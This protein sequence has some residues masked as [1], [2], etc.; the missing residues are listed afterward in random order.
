MILTKLDVI[1]FIIKG[2]IYSQNT[3]DISLKNDNKNFIFKYN[4]KKKEILNELKNSISKQINIFINEIYNN[5]INNCVKE[6]MN[7]I[8]DE[9]LNL[10]KLK[11]N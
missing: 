11:K 2:K 5:Q 9:A 10:I 4:L 3:I 6:F 8:S 1:G 7:K